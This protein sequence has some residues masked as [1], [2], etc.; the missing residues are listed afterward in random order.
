MP[1]RGG[2][3]TQT[4]AGISPLSRSIGAAL[5]GFDARG[6]R[7][8]RET[9]RLIRTLRHRR[10][11]CIRR[12]GVSRAEAEELA[13]SLSELDPNLKIGGVLLAPANLAER[14]EVVFVDRGLLTDVGAARPEFAYRHVWRAGDVL[15]WSDRLVL[16][17]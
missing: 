2:N 5:W 4:G 9:R 17:G 14:A 7:P 11:A 8:E 12:A 1:W 10:V 3:R 16:S 13:A 15:I 6:P